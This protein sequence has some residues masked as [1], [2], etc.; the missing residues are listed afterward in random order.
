MGWGALLRPCPG[1]VDPLSSA[2]SQGLLGPTAGSALGLAAGLCSRQLSAHPTLYEDTILPFGDGETEMHKG[3]LTGS[4]SS[5]R[6][7][8]A[9]GTMGCRCVPG[10]RL[11]A[12]MEGT[13]SRGPE[14]WASSW[15]A[16]WVLAAPSFF[17]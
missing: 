8:D 4:G 16:G 7:H 14:A 1:A 10:P 9:S 3:N 11:M 6:D 17:Q 12:G 5:T 15:A 2:G 13:H